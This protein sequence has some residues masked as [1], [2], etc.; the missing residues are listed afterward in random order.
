MSFTDAVRAGF[1]NWNIVNG[2]ASRSEYWWWALFL[3]L[4]SLGA[5][6]VLAAIAGGTR[7]AGA[8][9]IG[10]AGVVLVVA[11]LIV[12]VPSITLT[13]RR[14]HDTGRSGWW[15]LISLIPYLGG[16]ILL[17]FMCLDGTPGPNSWGN[18][19]GGNVPGHTAPGAPLIGVADELHKLEALR[20]A[21]T[22]SDEEFARQ[23]QKLL[24]G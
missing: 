16:L 19:P 23:R 20:V 6:F 22:I 7:S 2:R 14:L 4:G 8:G 13:V 15:L 3:F 5:T 21:G 17:V 24:P 1:H 10:I 18:R 12:L 11:Y 9:A